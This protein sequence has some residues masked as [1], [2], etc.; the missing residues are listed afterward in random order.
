MQQ[1]DSVPFSN[2]L[3]GYPPEL[4]QWWDAYGL[5]NWGAK[6]EDTSAF[7]GAGDLQ[8]FTGDEDVRRT[9]P[10]GNGALSR[11]LATTLQPKYGAQM[12]GDAT[13]VSVDP[14]KDARAHHLHASRPVAHRR[15]K[16]RDHGHS[17]IHHRATDFRRCPTRSTKP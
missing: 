8:Y 11:Q 13:I 15:G 9:L 4:K 2:Y 3:K 17:E 5:S 1:L 7:V 6:S 16:I 10:G 14:Q 12:V